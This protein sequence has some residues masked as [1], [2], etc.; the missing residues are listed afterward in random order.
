MKKL[1]ITLFLL[2]VI[3]PIYAQITEKSHS[4]YT[5]N[6]EFI[7]QPPLQKGI[8]SAHPINKDV[9]KI[10]M[11]VNLFD[12]YI[13]YLKSLNKIGQETRLLL[14]YSPELNIEE[15][16]E[17]PKLIK[18]QNL[19]TETVL[20]KI[21]EFLEKLQTTNNKFLADTLDKLIA[22]S[23]SMEEI[24]N[25]LANKLGL[26]K[27][28]SDTNI[29][30]PDSKF[31]ILDNNHIA[32]IKPTEKNNKIL[33]LTNTDNGYF[34]SMLLDEASG[35]YSNLTPSNDG[36]YI[37]YTTN[38]SLQIVE[39]S[40]GQTLLPLENN[41]ILLDM[42][43][44]PNKNILAGI[45]LNKTTQERNFFLYDAD[46]KENIKVKL[47]NHN[48]PENTLYSYPYWS[49][50]SSKL[51]FASSQALHLIDLDKKKSIPFFIRLKDSFA[52]LIWSQDSNSIAITEVVGQTR[53]HAEFDDMDF[54]KTI[55]HRYTI[56]D[57]YEVIEDYAQRTETRY[58]IKPITFSPND[59]VMYIE[60]R[61]LG[62]KMDSAVWEFP[63]C[64]LYLSP[65]PA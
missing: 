21:N 38:L 15:Y 28:I 46:K 49:E 48:I 60:G 10:N 4:F 24:T 51:I 27:V 35:Y 20:E 36:R 6:L 62:K 3:T 44:A 63:N 17:N 33:L 64:K 50:N 39:V 42:R 57:N 26:K 32:I 23:S 34:S 11:L 1:L 30:I 55:L 25:D 16:D 40:S 22:Y 37:A 59:R 52:E 8:N 18:L 13:R 12:G 65:L 7:Y 56:K 9:P 45:I 19:D 29:I 31:C 14:L 41:K 53:N 43:W 2:F 47:N 54:R 58:T 5:S 61:M